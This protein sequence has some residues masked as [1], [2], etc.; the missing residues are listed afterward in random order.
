MRS[1]PMFALT[2]VGRIALACWA[3]EQATLVACP[4]RA[5]PAS[6][7]HA[8]FTNH[9]FAL[10]SAAAPSRCAR[11]SPSVHGRRR[12]STS[13]TVLGELRLR[14]GRRRRVPARGATASAFAV[15]RP[16]PRRGHGLRRLSSHRAPCR[17]SVRKAELV[18]SGCAGRIFF[19]LLA[20]DA[21]AACAARHSGALVLGCPAHVAA[22][23]G[24]RDL[25]T[26]PR[27]R[28]VW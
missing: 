26:L 20:L 8:V 12:S 5:I 25:A 14:S 17:P 6:L 10:S 21:V 4:H 19:A 27:A 15:A 3:Q 23:S 13:P 11:L 22:G 1:L 16:S 18:S 2:T 24:R 28:A 9:I 7:S